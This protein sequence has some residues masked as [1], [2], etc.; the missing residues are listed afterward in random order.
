MRV[1]PGSRFSDKVVYRGFITKYTANIPISELL[2]MTLSSRIR[3]IFSHALISCLLV[4]AASTA[5]AFAAQPNSYDVEVVIFSYRHPADN[6]E[7][8]PSQAAKDSPASGGYSSGDVR[9]LPAGAYK[10]NGISNGLRQ[11]S[12]YS[13]VFHRAWR[14]PAYGDASAVNLPVQAVAAN[15]RENIEGNVRLI[16]ERFLHLDTDLQM[17]QAAANRNPVM[18]L[19][20]SRVSPVYTLREKRRIKSNVIH[21]FDNPR[22][23]M[24]ATVTPYYSPEES[25][26]L[27]EDAQA[28]ETVDT[29]EQPVSSP[30]E[31]DQLTR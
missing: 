19:N 31:D 7:V 3:N 28:E 23:G 10:L 8:W 22:F 13:V 16:R 9:E 27:L 17:K 2:D 4:Y 25:R 30:Q 11:S 29:E 12:N 24:I 6:G 5:P 20:A 15:G 1:R 14:Q 21:Y 26:Q 18:E